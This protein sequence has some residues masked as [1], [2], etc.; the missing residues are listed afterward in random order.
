MRASTVRKSSAESI[1]GGG[2]ILSGGRGCHGAYTPFTTGGTPGSGLNPTPISTCLRR[3]R[4]KCASEKDCREQNAPGRKNGLG[5]R[6]R[7]GERR[8]GDK[9]R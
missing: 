7:A 6:R 2:S 8:V 1:K 3:T 5:W 9:Q 4:C